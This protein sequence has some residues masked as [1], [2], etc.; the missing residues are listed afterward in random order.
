MKN[1]LL[2]SYSVEKYTF[3]QVGS[4]RV[5]ELEE[6]EAELDSSETHQENVR[7]GL[8]ATYCFIRLS[9]TESSVV[10]RTQSSFL[11]WKVVSADADV[12]ITGEVKYHHYFNYENDILVAEMGHYESEQYTKEI[13]YSI[14][15]EMFGAGSPR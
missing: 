12:F 7:S 3:T 9:D 8:S 1:R 15:Q 6:P 4:G 10:W 5:A 14:I 11:L 13:L 2:T